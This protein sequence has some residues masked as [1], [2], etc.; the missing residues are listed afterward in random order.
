MQL[1]SYKPVLS[2]WTSPTA[3]SIRSSPE[4]WCR[5]EHC[6]RFP[7][8]RALAAADILYGWAPPEKLITS[9][10]EVLA[11]ASCFADYFVGYLA[12][13]G[14][15]RWQLPHE[16]HSACDEDLWVALGATL[17]ISS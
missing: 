11:F 3:T 17:R 8:N 2:T 4:T 5:G 1:M 13:A 7:S 15:N 12:N 16:R 9:G 6:H 10:T 14:F